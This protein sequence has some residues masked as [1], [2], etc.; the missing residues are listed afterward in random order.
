LAI[1]AIRRRSR[2]AD[3]GAASQRR[4]CVLL[5]V[6]C[7]VRQISCSVRGSDRAGCL[8]PDA[9]SGTDRPPA[10]RAHVRTDGAIGAARHNANAG[11]GGASLG[12]GR[13]DFW[14]GSAA[15]AMIKEIFAAVLIGFTLPAS[16]QAQAGSE[17][18]TKLAIPAPTLTGQPQDADAIT[19]R[20]PQ[21]L[22]GIRLF[23]PKVC[24]PQREWDDL[25]RK[26]LDIGPDGQ[27]V[28]ESEQYRS[29][30]CSP[31]SAGC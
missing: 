12:D 6:V 24:R 9:F 31:G 10:I 26:G 18:T 7:G 20:P 4:E 17:L 8:F 30:H 23:G 1:L 2:V 27:T 14:I 16:A 15:A 29:L 28:V 11:L 22:P 19:C 3:V 21:Q 13:K 25:H 5:A